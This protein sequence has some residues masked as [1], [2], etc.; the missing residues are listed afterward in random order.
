MTAYR[1][2]CSPPWNAAPAR[3]LPLR[4]DRQAD[5]RPIILVPRAHLFDRILSLRSTTLLLHTVKDR[6]GNGPA[7]YQGDAPCVLLVAVIMN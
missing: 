5:P 2:C 7:A 1:H 3:G 6:D 4:P